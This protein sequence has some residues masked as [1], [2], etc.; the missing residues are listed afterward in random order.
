M[1]GYKGHL[2]GGFVAYVCVM[3]LFIAVRPPLTI[4]FEWLCFTLAGALFPDVDVKSRGQKYFYYFVFA[5]FAM[6]MCQ[7]KHYIVSCLSLI[8]ITP[9]LCRHRG[10]FHDAR[11]LIVMPIM[12]WMF[13]SVLFPCVMRPLFLNIVFFIVGCLSHM[14]LDRI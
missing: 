3:L 4:A 12:V 10:I 8:M 2:V 13:V 1:P 6:L 11:F 9:M 7:G 5:L 14:V